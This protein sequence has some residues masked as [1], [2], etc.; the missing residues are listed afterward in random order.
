[1][2]GEMTSSLTPHPFDATCGRERDGEC[3][4]APSVSCGQLVQLQMIESATSMELLQDC[5]LKHHTMLQTAGCLRSVMS[6]EDKMTIVSDFLRW[7]IIDRNVCVIDRFKAGLSALGLYSALQQYPT[8]LSPV[9]C[10]VEKQLIAEVLE[11]LFRPDLSPLGSNRRARKG[12]T[13]GFWADYLLDCQEGQAA[14]SVE[15]VLM[16]ATGLN[17]LP[18]SGLI[19]QPYPMANTCAN[20]M[21][22][23]QL[24]HFELFKSNMDFGIQNAPGF[25]CF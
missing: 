21:K 2:P 3:A 13:L 23:P 4:H 20:T 10:H 8:L 1:M 9:L 18:P 22:L 15:E 16:F 25:G 17:S 12:R 6:L 7:F 5:T 14:V 19:P 11:N 24:D